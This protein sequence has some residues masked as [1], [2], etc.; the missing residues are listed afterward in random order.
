MTALALICVVPS[1]P[2]IAP[3]TGRRRRSRRTHGCH[4]GIP[5]RAFAFSMTAGMST[6]HAEAVE[7]PSRQTKS[8]VSS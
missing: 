2:T 3:V 8:V 4:G 6:R 1:S 5:R 7:T